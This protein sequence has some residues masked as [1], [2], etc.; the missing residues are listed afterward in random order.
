MA[1]Q[2]T[3]I[4][5][6]VDQNIQIEVFAWLNRAVGGDGSGSRFISQE[7]T[8]GESLGTVMRRLTHGYPHLHQNMWDSQSGQLGGGIQILVNDVLLGITHTMDSEVR[9][10]DRIILMER[11]G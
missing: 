8:P 10:G 5:T 3:T 11:S 6:A 1:E 4:T 2:Q 9:N 7:F